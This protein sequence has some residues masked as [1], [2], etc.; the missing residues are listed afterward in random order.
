MIAI[1]GGTGFL[2]KKL[3]E[4]I[5]GITASRSGEIYVD[6]TKPRTISKLKKFSILIHCA[7]KVSYT[8]LPWFQSYK[9]LYE[10]NVKGTENLVRILKPKYFVFLSSLAIF[11]NHKLEKIRPKNFYGLTKYLAELKCLEYARKKKFKLLIVRLPMVYDK[12]ELRREAYLFKKFSFLLKFIP[13]LKFKHIR[14]IEREECIKRICELVKKGKE[15]II[16]IRGKLVSLYE[17][18]DV[19]ET[20]KK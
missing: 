15:G 8:W 17:F 16:N 2:C 10:V 7:A 20:K 6:L 12:K 1:I 14:V 4:K 9:K 19:I 18:I 11:E 13:L 3:K 5:G